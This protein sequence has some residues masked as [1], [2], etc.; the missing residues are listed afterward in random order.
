MRRMLALIIGLSALPL[1]AANYSI[2][3][4]LLPPGCSR[5][6]ATVTCNNLSLDWNDTISVSGTGRT[7]KIN[8][9]ASLSNAK[10]NQNGNVSQLSIQITGSLSTDSGFVA[11]ANISVGTTANLGY[12]NRITGN[13]SAQ[14]IN[15]GS[16]NTLAGNLNANSIT[17]SSANQIT[18]NITAANIS[19]GSSNTLLGGLYGG[20]VQTGSANQIT[21]P[22]QGTDITIASSNNQIQGNIS[23]TGTLDIGSG[24]TVNGNLSAA[25][26]TSTSAVNLTGTVSATNSF[27]LA[28]G[29]TLV[30]AVT[31]PIVDLQPSGI[32]VTGDISA[33]T[34]LRVGSGGG[35]YGDVEAGQVTL[36]ASNALVDGNVIADSVVLVDWGGRITGDVTAP[37]ITNNGSIGGQTYCDSSDGYTPTSCST[38][39]AQVDHF[40]LSHSGSMA[41]CES[42]YPVNVIACGNNDCTSQAD[43]NATVEIRDKSNANIS[44]IADFNGGS[45]ANVQLNISQ[46]GVYEL[47]VGNVSGVTPASIFRCV[48]NLCQFEVK[49]SLLRF[50][51]KDTSDTALA[52]QTAGNVFEVDLQAITSDEETGQC[53]AALSNNQTVTLDLHCVDPNQCSNGSWLI[54]NSTSLG[55]APGNI[56]ADFGST[57]QATLAL[58]YDDAGKI[59]LSA[60]TRSNLNNK[61]LSGTATPFVVKPASVGFEIINQQGEASPVASLSGNYHEGNVFTGAGEAFSI[62]LTA[63]NALG[64][65]TENFGNEVQPS[66]LVIVGHQLL[67]PVPGQLGSLA[68]QSAFSKVQSAPGVFANNSISYSEVGVVRLSADVA[69]SYL[70]AGTIEPVSIS[71]P[72]GRFVP[73]HFALQDDVLTPACGTFSYMDQPFAIETLISAQNA[74]DNVTQNYQ[75]NY[76]KALVADLVIYQDVLLG[77]RLSPNQIAT[78]WNAGQSLIDQDIRFV[79]QTAADGPY[80][81]LQTGVKIRDSDNVPMQHPSANL[82]EAQPIHSGSP[83]KIRYGRAWLA[84]TYGPEIEPLPLPLQIQYFDINTWKLNTI[85]NCTSFDKAYVSIVQNSNNLNSE[86]SG[87]GT[88]VKG[89]PVLPLAGFVLSEPNKTGEL[90]LQWQLSQE[91]LKFDWQSNGTSEGPEA[92][93][94]FGR[95]R[96]NDRILFQREI[97]N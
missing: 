49:D 53:N 7:L 20:T 82:S 52:N 39:A 85:D 1:W 12:L 35:V 68:N 36:D 75:G 73:T 32:R 78:T 17:T 80:D 38:P 31:A 46:A 5:S 70:G 76:A 65:T 96:G 55:D 25:T 41:T 89:A 40:L 30:G 26:I 42:L 60:S 16:S 90:Q 33:S 15:T 79:R 19:L 8:G 45:Q 61:L 18:G 83:T 97:F 43:I 51:N 11:V 84:N 92:T 48:N 4:G 3:N 50:V 29:S 86:V 56:Q 58:R 9:N 54:A 22:I 24:A 34:S 77:S 69:S 81:A 28:S 14:T 44:A 91:W 87:S 74:N 37:H 64:G 71:Q 94:T 13:L 66:K 95:Y 63:L 21:G 47:M 93:A 27:T 23:A 6:G 88:V 2:P 72:V 67:G 57:G 62:R 10:I 59:S